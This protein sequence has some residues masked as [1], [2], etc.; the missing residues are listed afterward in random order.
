MFDVVWAGA[1][2]CAVQALL[3]EPLLQR[4]GIAGFAGEGAMQGE[5]A[6]HRKDLCSKR[7]SNMT[8]GEGVMHR[9]D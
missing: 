1:C 7:W 3:P 8:Q 6:K 4:Q 9:N 5:G 2:S